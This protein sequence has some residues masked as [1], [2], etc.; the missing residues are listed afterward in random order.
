MNILRPALF[1]SFLLLLFLI[2]IPRVQAEDGYRLWLRYE[3]VKDK[4]L[5]DSYRSGISS[6]LAQGGTETERV[7]VR[8]LESGLK[9]M[10]DSSIPTTTCGSLRRRAHRRHPRNLTPC[11]GV[12]ME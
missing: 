11:V 1:I 12:E 7:L 9:G 6:I 5:R 4:A 3:K 2:D 8:E 10:L